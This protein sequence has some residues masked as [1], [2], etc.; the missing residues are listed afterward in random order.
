MG[1]PAWGEEEK[2]KRVREKVSILIR[3]ERN[4]TLH[5]RGQKPMSSQ[6]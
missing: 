3:F 4:A 6:S 5:W 1:I 2:K